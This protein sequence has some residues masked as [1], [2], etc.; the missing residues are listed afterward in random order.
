MDFTVAVPTAGILYHE[1]TEFVSDFIKAVFEYF[2]VFE[3]SVTPE[4]VESA[5]DNVLSALVVGT[6]VSLQDFK[7]QDPEDE[8]LPTDDV[9]KAILEHESMMH[10]DWLVKGAKILDTSNYNR[11]DWDATMEGLTHKDGLLGNAIFAQALQDLFIRSLASGSWPKLNPYGDGEFAN[12]LKR[13]LDLSHPM[14]ME[15]LVQTVTNPAFT[16]GMR[17]FLQQPVAAEG[18]PFAGD[19][20]LVW[21]LPYRTTP[22]NAYTLKE[23]VPSVTVAEKIREFLAPPSRFVP[24]VKE[25]KSKKRRTGR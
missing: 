8:V 21:G 11:G 17:T 14:V 6:G 3:D 20:F 19:V 1:S 5:V 12:L 13:I 16:A 24:V 23:G 18:L 9:V 15:R 4:K 2:L 22:W 10:D 25:P 7:P